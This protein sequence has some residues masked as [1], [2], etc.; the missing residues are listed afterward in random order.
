MDQSLL[1]ILHSMKTKL[2]NLSTNASQIIETLDDPTTQSPTIIQ[3]AEIIS[4]KLQ[5]LLNRL[6]S[7]LTNYFRL[8]NDP[9]PDDISEISTVQ[10][11]AEDILCEL[12]VKIKEK[13]KVIERENQVNRDTNP[14]LNS[15]LPKLSLP[16]FDGDILQWSTFWDQFSSNID[17]RNLTDVDKLLY[18]KASLKGEAK[19]IVEGLETT[20]KN[21]S[22]ALVTLKNRYGKENHIIDAHYSAL[23]RVKASTAMNVTE[24]RQTL[25]E[26]ERHLRVLKSLGEDINHNH[27]RFLIMEKFPQEIIY[28]MKM[29][30][31]T[32]SI[33]EIRKCLEVIITA[34]ED[35]ERVIQGK[36]EDNYT[37][38]SLHAN[39]SG[40]NNMKL[41]SKRPTSKEMSTK[42]QDKNRGLFQGRQRS[43]RK[44]FKRKW[45]E[46]VGN[47]ERQHEKKR[48]LHCIFCQENH[49]NDQCKAFTTLRERKNKLINR[50][51]ACLRI[52][53]TVKTCVR[54]PKC[55]HCNEIGSHNRALC[56]RTLSKEIEP[57]NTLMQ[58]NAKGTTILQTAVVNA[59]SEKEGHV[60][61]KC[62]ILL[63][64]GSQRTYITREV[65][66]QLNL[67]IEEESR[68]SIFT[69]GSKTPQI[70]DSPIVKIKLLTRTNETLLLYANVVP[71]ISQCVPYPDTELGHWEN[72]TVLADDGSLSSRIDILIGNDYYHNVMKTGK[73]KIRENLYLVNSKLGWIL[74]GETNLKPVDELSVITYFLSCGETKLNK[75]DLPLNNVDIKSLW[76]LE[77]IGIT[78][79]P[80]I[81]ADE[82][83]VKTF[84]E[85]TEVI[86]NRYTVSW[87]WT[88]Y[89]PSLS[90]NFGLSFGRLVSLLKRLDSNTL[91]EYDNILKE[92]ISKG[93]IELVSKHTNQEKHPVHYLP[94]HCVRQK[95]KPI[96]IV[97]DASAKTKDSNSLNECLYCGPMMLEDLTGLL[98]K[99]RYH[100][101]ALSADVEKAFLQIALHERDRDVTRFLWIKDLNK[102]PTE[103]NIIYMRFCR[104]PFGII[105]SPFLLN[106]T[107]KLHLSNDDKPKVRDLANDIYVDNLV[108]GSSSVAEALELYNDSREAFKQMSMNLREWSSNSYEFT[109]QI[110][111]S[112]KEI[113]VKILGLDWDLKEDLLQLRYK[114]DSNANNK[115]EVLRVI[116]SIY[117][118]C[119]FVAPHILPAKLFLQELWK[120]KIKWD[121]T[122]SKQMK[123]EWSTIQLNPADVA[124]K[125]YSTCEDKVKWLAG[126]QYL[127]Q[128]CD[129][130]PQKTT[131]TNSLLS[132]EDLPN[133]SEDEEVEMDETIS[134]NCN[135]RLDEINNQCK[136][137][138]KEKEQLQETYLEEIK[139]LQEE[140]F[141]DEVNGKDTNLSRNLGLFRDIDGILRCKGRMRNTNWS[142]D[143]RYP[144]LLPKDSQ[145]TNR[146]IMETH[147]KNYHVGVNH[148]LS[149]IRETYWILQGKR[150]VQ[151]LLKKC[152]TCV[153]HG[154]GPYKLPPTPALPPERVNY[155]SPFT[156]TGIDYLG[157]VLVNNGNGLEKRWICLFT[158][159]AIRAIHLEVVQDLSAEEGLRA[160]RR[161]IATRGLPTLITSDNALQ[162][163]LMSEILAKPYC[164]ENKIRWRFI[165]ALAPWFG[166]FYERL[167]GIVKH[168]MKRTLQKHCLKDCELSTVMKE[169]EAVVNT[170][171]LTHIDAE[172]DHILKPADFLAVGKCI[173]VENTRK[174]PLAEG[175]VTKRELVK[176]WKRAL[177]IQEEFREMFSNR[178]LL[179]LRERYQHSH[180][181]P[182][183]TS[184][185]EPQEGQIVQIKGE[186]PNRESWRVGKIT[187]LMKGKDGFSRTAKVKVD[188]SEY[189]RSI[190]HLYPLEMDEQE[191]HALADKPRPS[192]NYI[193]SERIT[194]EVHEETTGET[195]EIRS[196]EID[197]PEKENDHTIQDHNETMLEDQLLPEEITNENEVDL[198][199]EEPRPK[200][201]A[202][203][204]ALEKI[205][206]WTQNLIVLFGEEDSSPGRFRLGEICPSHIRITE[207]EAKDSVRCDGEEGRFLARRLSAAETAH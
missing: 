76:D 125:P 18:L 117:D 118:P 69:F 172:L 142:F 62:R 164:I 26:I 9:A 178:Y 59:K 123:E 154:G 80:K 4:S 181:D 71:Y 68:L 203:V 145:L 6:S 105:S 106:A 1:A 54:K 167:M 34:R 81:S 136:I 73:L 111:D 109:E 157:P 84:N 23:Y 129:T 152:P 46:P 57:T 200:R 188:N 60:E 120:T 97:Y 19:K 161:M 41:K 207:C 173:T 140:Y 186:H 169:I 131:N 78:D 56:P 65:A 195:S 77:S 20:N 32:E 99:F 70:I 72:K 153:K 115:R 143:K 63:D 94:H 91:L 165:P 182:R 89:P 39:A 11:E 7:E 185:L 193:P 141:K 202:A 191:A 87:P 201:E 31:N 149:I 179:S 144:I 55:A 163:K 16:E 96:R 204:R 93:V 86:D 159:L 196:G 66:K 192:Y 189:I 130:W 79:S 2:Q 151:K 180:R 21:Y 206:E 45:E 27:L 75:P 40:D 92:Q 119:G 128:A 122:F 49:F 102:P 110:P 112:S 12:K 113:R 35:A 150:Q 160:L 52:G 100:Q 14:N 98:V 132:R 176:G 127:L 5:T 116:A 10:L 138:E 82:E 146:I 126:P 64:S 168:C 28:E 166:G 198:S 158:C 85:S 37:T 205:K 170:R 33:E 171:P 88:E 53:H 67:P 74:S 17:K 134:A 177:K 22:I 29:K 103:D 90:T 50:C 184:K 108:T 156:F 83:A 48:K 190:S 8:S 38:Q 43:F 155:S 148:T 3:E 187:K 13:I 194:R 139:K 15:R 199:S 101:I 107:I 174:E 197:A 147:N 58:L 47:Q 124:T 121:T 162:F 137:N 51:Y 36:S 95:E 133:E 25:N 61:T 114:I 42:K 24:V 104:V 135:K 183:V 30:I 175:T 44:Q